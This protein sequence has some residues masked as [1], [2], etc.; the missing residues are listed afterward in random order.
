MRV[1]LVDGNTKDGELLMAGLVGIGHEVR[2][3]QTAADALPLALDFIPEVILAKKLLADGTVDDLAFCVRK[4]PKLDR[5]TIVGCTAVP[6]EENGH[7]RSRV[8]LYL[9]TSSFL[10]AMGDIAGLR[11]IDPWFGSGAMSDDKTKKRPQDSSKVN[12]NEPYEVE[13]WSHSL[14]VTPDRLREI[15]QRVGTGA[16][17]VKKAAKQ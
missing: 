11:S 15:V 17:A 5:T 12:V 10:S 13:Y 3:V 9:T 2:F 4:H 7:G 8:D 6:W 1:L 14:G 16:E